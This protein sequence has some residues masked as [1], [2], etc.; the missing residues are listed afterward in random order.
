MRALGSRRVEQSIER[1][2]RCARHGVVRIPADNRGT[3]DHLIATWG[4]KTQDRQGDG[5]P[6]AGNDLCMRHVEAGLNEQGGNGVNHRASDQPDPR[7]SWPARDAGQFF[8]VRQD[9]YSDLRGRRSDLGCQAHQ[10]WPGRRHAASSAIGLDQWIV[11]LH[12]A[13]R[14]IIDFE[15]EC[16]HRDT[17]YISDELLRRAIA[18][19]QE[20]NLRN[21]APGSADNANGRDARDP[22]QRLLDLS[23]AGIRR[24]RGADVGDVHTPRLHVHGVKLRRSVAARGPPVGGS[25]EITHPVP[26]HK[27]T[28]TM[29]KEKY[30]R[31]AEVATKLQVSPKTVA[32]WAKEGRLPYLATLGGHRRF[33]ASHI[34]RLVGDLTK[35]EDH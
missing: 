5:L 35:L 3:A 19:G 14:P 1:S 17:L 26:T 23:E 18:P 28:I 7:R 20:M 31:T 22:R 15:P 12:D 21:P 11:E 16:G 9:M 30:L 8:P 32:R 4:R 33:P 6:V 34:E 10:R 13:N 24:L 29:P 2:E 27:E 25:K